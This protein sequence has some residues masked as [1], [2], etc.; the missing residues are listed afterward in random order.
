MRIRESSVGFWA[1]KQHNPSDLII[2]ALGVMPGTIEMIKNGKM[3]SYKVQVRGVN[4]SNV[5]NCICSP[6]SN[7]SHRDPSRICPFAQ[8][9]MI[10]LVVFKRFVR[11]NSMAQV[12]DINI[13]GSEDKPRYKCAHACI[14]RGSLCPSS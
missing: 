5:G 11:L 7:S 3:D 2:M 1:A 10:V 4:R 14:Q 12:Q 9:R 13:L 6:C 8:R